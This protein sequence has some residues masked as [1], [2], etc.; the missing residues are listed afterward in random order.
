MSA[1]KEEEQAVSAKLSSLEAERESGRILLTERSE[2]LAESRRRAVEVEGCLQ[3]LENRV[4][5]LSSRLAE[6]DTEDERRAEEI[7][8]LDVEITTFENERIGLASTLAV[9]TEQSGL[10]CQEYDVSV[11][12]IGGRSGEY[13]G[14]RAGSS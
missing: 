6:L 7:Q 9:L 13:K 4:E 11:A 2:V 3:R 10:A 12:E 5:M 1:S 8:T 14:I